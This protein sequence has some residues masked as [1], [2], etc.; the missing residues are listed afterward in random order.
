MK[1]LCERDREAITYLMYGLVLS[2]IAM[3]FSGNSRPA[4]GSEHHVSHYIEMTMTHEECSALHGEKVG[5]GLALVSRLYHSFSELTDSEIERRLY[6][7]TRADD[8]YVADLFG[9]LADE[10][11]KENANDCAIGITAG[12][13][14]AKLGEIRAVI[15][16][17][18]S[19]CEICELLSICNAPKTL[20]DIGIDE[21]ELVPLLY[22]AAPLV[23]NRLTLMR[24]LRNFKR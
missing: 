6:D 15:A 9:E 8:K 2:G 22:D 3:Q 19:E 1:K 16:E 11:Y 14:C 13:I 10:I 20:S 4:S 23:R 17:I 12:Q 5:V 18:P 24:L 21:G 7:Y